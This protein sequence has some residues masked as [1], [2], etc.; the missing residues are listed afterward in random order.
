MEVFSNHR[1]LQI[2]SNSF[3]LSVMRFWKRASVCAEGKS[4]KYMYHLKPSKSS[5]LHLN[6]GVDEWGLKKWNDV[7]K[8]WGGE[9]QSGV[10]LYTSC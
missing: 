3:M 10:T 6:G 2:E 9:V 1:L 4:S 8:F 5:P 7:A